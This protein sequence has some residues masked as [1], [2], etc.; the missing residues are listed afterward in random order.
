MELRINEWAHMQ[1][2]E[3]SKV[4]DPIY[5]EDCVKDHDLKTC[6]EISY[7]TWLRHLEGVLA[8]SG[9]QR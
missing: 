1:I 6:F 2:V 3:K 7:P 8:S 9:Y 5:I 4:G